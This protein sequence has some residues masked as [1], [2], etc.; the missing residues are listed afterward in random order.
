MLTFRR[1]GASKDG[2][3]SVVE[4]FSRDMRIFVIGGGSEEILD[5]Y[6][7]RTI[8]AGSRKAKL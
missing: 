6:S 2:K 8:H 7:I 4:Q 3:G 5:D 1:L